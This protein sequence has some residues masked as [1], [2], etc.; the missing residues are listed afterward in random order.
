MQ[1]ALLENVWKLC[2]T[3]CC[4]DLEEKLTSEA[5]DALG[6]GD[7]GDDDD[8]DDDQGDDDN[9]DDGPAAGFWKVKCQQKVFCRRKMCGIMVTVWRKLVTKQTDYQTQ[10]LDQVQSCTVTRANLERKGF[11]KRIVR[12]F[13]LLGG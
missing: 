13:G 3:A 5:E 4:L 1:K 12:T 7:D 8:D 6:S 9:R 2:K 10:A 11:K